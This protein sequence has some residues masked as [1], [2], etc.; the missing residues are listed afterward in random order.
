MLYGRHNASCVVLASDCRLGGLCAADLGKFHRRVHATGFSVS[1]TAKC[2][3]NWA[4]SNGVM[5]WLQAGR[6]HHRSDAASI[7][8][9]SIDLSAA[10][11]VLPA[12]NLS[13]A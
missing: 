1:A 11:H 7:E 2:R 3:H 8:P 9:K 6:G 13:D 10:R 12:E 5:Q 4:V